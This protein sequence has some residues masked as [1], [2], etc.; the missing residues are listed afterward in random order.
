MK[1][2]DYLFPEMIE[3][4]ANGMCPLC[5]EMV[6]AFTDALSQREYEISGMCMDCQTDIFCD[7]PEVD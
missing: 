3:K 4:R 7:E 1:P 5:G 6:G 2:V